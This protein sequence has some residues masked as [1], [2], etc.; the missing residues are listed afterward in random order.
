MKTL[1]F[2]SFVLIFSLLLVS[3][4]KEPVATGD[5]QKIEDRSV[6]NGTYTGIFTAKYGLESK[7]GPVTLVLKN[8]NFTC[9]GDYSTVPAGGSGT[10]YTKYGRITF[11]SVGAIG[12]TVFDNN[13]ILSGVYDYSLIGKKLT[14]SKERSYDMSYEYNLEK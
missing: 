6:L 4:N 14:I 5:D 9:S 8:G 12:T 10:F 1:N 3:C 13:L 2:L 11:Y 7:I